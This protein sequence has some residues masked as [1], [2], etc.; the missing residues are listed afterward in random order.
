MIIRDIIIWW[1]IFNSFL[2]EA[3]ELG[4]EDVYIE[5]ESPW[6]NGFN[7]RFNGSLRDESLNLEYFLL[8]KKPECSLA[9]DERTIIRAHSLK[10]RPPPLL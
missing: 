1:F 8:L 4:S 3:E 10:Y 2:R 6:E 7:E 5:P 9:Q